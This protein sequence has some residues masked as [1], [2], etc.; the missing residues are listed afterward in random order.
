[1]APVPKALAAVKAAA[2]EGLLRS[3]G[4][5]FREELTTA[6]TANKPPPVMKAAPASLKL[7]LS[8]SAAQRVK[9]N[10]SGDDGDGDDGNC[11]E[12]G[13]DDDDNAFG[14]EEE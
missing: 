10:D 14:E 3:C 12:G 5:T 11:G 8:A 9:D 2:V 4:G 13:D 6:T 1:M 7:T